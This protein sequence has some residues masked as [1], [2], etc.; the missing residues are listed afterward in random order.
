[1]E[2]I[3]GGKYV[4][5]NKLLIY[6]QLKEI[7]SQHEASFSDERGRST[8][9]RKQ[10]TKLSVKVISIYIHTDNL[11]KNFAMADGMKCFETVKM[12]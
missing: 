12:S 6:S 2:F 11:I 9:S 8:Y 1:M 7:K 5:K 10:Q 3:P 4:R